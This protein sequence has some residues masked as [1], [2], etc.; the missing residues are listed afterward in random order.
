MLSPAPAGSLSLLKRTNSDFQLASPCVFQA[1]GVRLEGVTPHMGSAVATFHAFITQYD[2][3]SACEQ[4][5][6]VK[7]VLLQATGPFMDLYNGSGPVRPGLPELPLTPDPSVRTQRKRSPSPGQLS[8]VWRAGDGPASSQPR[9]GAAFGSSAI[10]AQA[11]I[12]GQGPLRP[13]PPSTHTHT[14]TRIS[15]P[16]VCLAFGLAGR[17][18]AQALSISGF[19][20]S[21]FGCW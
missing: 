3:I 1:I 10:L 15:P 7:N 4:V 16:G 21:F 13:D 9:P 8:V 18:E 20:G 14:Y 17:G 11:D 5:I 12:Q 2:F 6:N 19:W